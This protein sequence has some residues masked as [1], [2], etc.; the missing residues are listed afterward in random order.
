MIGSGAI[1]SIAIALM[2][3]KWRQTMVAAMGVMFGITMFVTLLSFMTG[4][5]KMLDGLI[6]NRTPHI[7]IYNE[8][9]ATIK[10]PIKKPDPQKPISS[11]P[12]DQNR[13]LQTS[14]IRVPFSEILK[15]IKMF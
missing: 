11:I 6:L 14:E 13:V 5:N 10:Q 8:M 9:K 1:S 12:S 7:R 15:K 4:L 2:K 3:A